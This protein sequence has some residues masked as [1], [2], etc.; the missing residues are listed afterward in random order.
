MA[1]LLVVQ[2]SDARSRRTSLAGRSLAW[3]IRARI[4]LIPKKFDGDASPQKGSPVRGP[5][6]LRVAAQYS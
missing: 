1:L 4:T 2:W 3:P 5:G 6:T